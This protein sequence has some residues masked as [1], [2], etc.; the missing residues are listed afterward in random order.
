MLRLNLLFLCFCTCVNILHAQI[1][2]VLPSHEVLQREFGAH[3]RT[4][5]LAPDKVFY[6]ETWFHFIGGNVSYEGIT[7]DL[8]AIAEAGISGVHFFHGQAGGKWPATGDEITCMSEKWEDAVKFVASECQRLGLRFTMQN[9]P[10]WA[11]AGGPW[12]KPENAMRTIIRREKRVSVDAL[13][14]L[15]IEKPAPSSEEWRDY[16]DIAVIAFPTPAGAKNPVPKPV[17]VENGGVHNFADLLLNKKELNLPAGGDTHSVVVG[18]EKPT[19]IRTLELSPVQTFNHGMCYDP[20]VRVAMFAINARGEETKVMDAPMPAANWQDNARMSVACKEVYDAVSYRVEITNKHNMRLK[21]MC[22]ISGARKNNWEAEAGWTLRAFERTSDDLI[23][24][25]E[26]YIDAKQIIDV[27]AFMDSAGVFRWKAPFGDE[28]TIM[29]I[30]H[31]NSGRKN[32]PAPPSGTGW[33]CDKYSYEAAQV[34][35]DGYIGHLSN[36]ALK[37][38]LLKG[39]L[40][41]SWECNVQTWTNKMEAEFKE[42]TGYNLR[43]WLPTLFGYVVDSPET[44][45]R[46][47]LDWRS[48]INELF[49]NR[50]YKTVSELGRASGLSVMYE[51][52]AG[53]VFP[54]DIMEYFKYADVPMCEFWH[55]FSLGYVG[56]LDFKPIK[57]TASAARLYGKPRVN[58]ESFTSFNLS[59]DERWGMLKEVADFNAVEGVTHNVF[60]TY[61]HN[62]QINFL[63]PGTSFGTS[64]GTPFL[65]GQ[66]WWPH[67]REFTTYLARCSYMLERGRAVSDVLWYLGDEFS[68]KPSQK[69]PF[70]SGYKYDYCNPDV[71]LNRLSVKDGRVVTPEGQ[72][73]R[74]IWIPENKRMLPETLERLYSLMKRGAIVV[75][76]PP[77]GIATL[78][79]GKAAQRRFDKAVRAIWGKCEAGKLKR[80][81]KGGIL[82]GVSIEQALET[83]KI[84]ADVKGEGVRWVHRLIQG[85]DCYFV[86]PL[87]EKSFEGCVQ[88]RATGSVELWNPVNGKMTVVD[89]KSE[90]GYTSVDISLLRGGSCFVVFHKDKVLGE[91]F[92]PSVKNEKSIG[93]EWSLTYPSGWGAPDTLRVKELK[94]WNALDVSAEAKAFSGTVTYAT[95]FVAD[96]LM[97]SAPLLL[98]LGSVNM[99]A[100]VKVNGK[101]LGTLWCEPYTID[102]SSA[103]A[104]GENELVVEVTSTWFNRLVYDASLPENERKTWT[105]SGPSSNN[106]LREYGLMGPVKLRSC[107][108]LCP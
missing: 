81:G 59:W 17:K 15:R 11:M 38:G 64:I 86:T 75:A 99:I 1:A 80:V 70:P 90:N 85:A 105:I 33:E 31:V 60:H 97:L 87:Q 96:K 19:V 68:H 9:C 58:A 14:E 107:L 77:K 79:G 88:F 101:K 100:V 65:R 2:Q 95:S 29:R 98:D 20:G 62:P 50:F 71:L 44:T 24:S 46:F 4:A 47:L 39:L 26:S 28:W 21:H 106:S 36:G 7:A 30:G 8:E 66:T 73:Y 108:N 63:K 54:A 6:P 12:I 69:F 89:G 104:E 16:K 76:S 42:H 53:D 18:Y 92:T 72:S 61:T 52:A 45:S 25:E 74:F 82:S 94:P 43:K 84:P 91:H 103:V 49:V 56:D 35:F 13:S 5:F 10:G 34:H 55:P 57:P 40:L 102:I 32:G 3:D 51:T 67:M 83:L 78:S 37:G 48:T 41:D 23:Q 93:G 27:S 22:L